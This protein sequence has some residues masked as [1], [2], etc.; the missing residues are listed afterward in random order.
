MTVGEKDTND[1]RVNRA[2]KADPPSGSSSSKRVASSPE[3]GEIS[4]KRPR[5]IVPGEDYTLDALKLLMREVADRDHER[6]RNDR[7]RA[8]LDR[9]ETE[10]WE[11]GVKV[12][13]LD[14][15]VKYLTKQLELAHGRRPSS[16]N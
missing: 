11:L 16:S 10:K 2:V 4:T 6:R 14:V 7:L 5:H 8:T 3:P 12:N 15:Q 1:P 9:V 13:A